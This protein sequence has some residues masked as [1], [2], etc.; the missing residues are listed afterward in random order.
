MKKHILFP[1]MAILGIFIASG[2]IHAQTYH[3]VN[4]ADFQF[5]PANLDIHVGDTV[6]W[7]N[8]QGM[9][10]V[11]G[12]TITF[13]SNPESFGNQPAP[14][15]WVYTF[16]F[17]IPG[18]YSYRCEVHPNTMFGTII[19][20]AS[21]VSVDEIKEA[22]RFELYPNPVKDE[23]HWKW[24]KNSSPTS[25]QIQIYDVTGK[26]T[27]SFQLGFESH[28]DVSNWTEGM[29]IYTITTA[30]HPVQTGKLFII[31]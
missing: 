30:D 31:K 19:V 1:V 13:P 29:Y 3:N 17:N 9:H 14:V 28:K 25:A 4:V 2:S 8:S 7:T 22:D 10:S 16:I 26:L 5:T 20:S 6:V 27:D 21:P 12:T 24:N 11:N 23:L 15:G 18:E